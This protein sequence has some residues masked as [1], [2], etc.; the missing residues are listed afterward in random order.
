MRPV[1]TD[2]RVRI[3]ASTRTGAAP[4]VAGYYRTGSGVP[5][6]TLMNTAPAGVT[7]CNHSAGV[8]AVADPRGWFG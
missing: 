5:V 3:F 6:G 1:G 4:D 7:I 8:R 2:G